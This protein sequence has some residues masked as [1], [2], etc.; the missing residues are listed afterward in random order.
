MEFTDVC[1]RLGWRGSGTKFDILPLV[2]SANGH[3]PDYF[4]IPPELVLQVPMSHPKYV[5]IY[6]FLHVPLLNTVENIFYFRYSWF[7]EL[8]LKWYA[9]PA[10]SGMM[11]DCG[12]LEFTAAPFN[13]WYMSTEIGC[14]NFCDTQRY[15]LLEVSVNAHKLHLI[16]SG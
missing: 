8:G 9:L 7:E 11:F 13:G 12:G 16:V 3:D 6:S 2:L 5:L 14:R 10:V 1:I 15:N 4:D